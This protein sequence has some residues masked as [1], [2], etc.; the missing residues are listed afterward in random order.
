M[1]V[2]D[3]AET[4][5]LL[6]NPLKERIRQLEDLNAK[7]TAEVDRMRPVVEAA[8]AYLKYD[9]NDKGQLITLRARVNSAAFEYEMS[10]PK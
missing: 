3:A 4:D 8:V 1:G 9:G 7:L 10:K 6:I 2:I 5:R